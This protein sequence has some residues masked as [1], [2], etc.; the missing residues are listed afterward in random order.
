MA[1]TSLSLGDKRLQPLSSKAA[2]KSKAGLR[3]GFF[4]GNVWG[5][6]LF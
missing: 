1:S 6:A 4:E 5:I 2:P 3:A